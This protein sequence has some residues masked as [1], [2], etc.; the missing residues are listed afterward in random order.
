MSEQNVEIVRRM[1][2]QTARGHPE[3]LYECFDPDV[4]WDTSAT[5][6]PEAG[7]YR[8]HEGVKEYRRRFWGAWE[9]PRNEPEEFIDAGDSVVVI[10]RMGGR[11]KGSGID[12]EQRF[13][14]VWT[15]SEG[16]VTRV[17]VYQDRSEALAAAGLRE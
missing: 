7:V 2:E 13:A 14:M 11:G 17:A 3:V 16:K 9:T 4:E 5:D 8:G 6:L 15:L 12:V 1:Y 10:A